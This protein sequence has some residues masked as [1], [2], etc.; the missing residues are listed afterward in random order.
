[1]GRPDVEALLGN[2]LF[3]DSS[4]FLSS[5]YFQL[6][7][8]LKKITFGRLNRQV[9]YCALLFDWWNGG[10]TLVKIRSMKLSSKERNLIFGVNLIIKM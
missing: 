10:K 8:S 1:L 2:Q 3:P 7:T 9:P 4:A 6:G 5:I